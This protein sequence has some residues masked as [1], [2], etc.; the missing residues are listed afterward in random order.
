MSFKKVLL[1]TAIAAVSTSSYAMEAMD[2]SSLSDT[3]GQDGLIITVTPPAAGIVTDIIWHDTDGYTTRT[4]AGAVVIDNMTI[5][6]DS[7]IRLDIDASGD[8]D[9]VATGNQA[10]LRIGVSLLGTTTISTGDLS[11][12]ASNGVGAAVSNQ[13]ATILPSMNLT[14]GSGSLA[15]IFLGNEED[16][17]SMINLNTTLTGGIDVT[18]FAI[19]DIDSSGSIA[20]GTLA[21]DDTGAA[22]A[23]LAAQ[24]AVDAT[25]SGLLV[26]LTQ[27]GTGAG[28]DIAMTNVA[29]GSATVMGD[30]EINGLDL[31]GTTINIVGK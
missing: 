10:G 14:I 16:G 28:I 2:D 1:A 7:G 8:V 19:N 13:T 12:A 31:D 11:V 18:N 30:V 23:N 20:I 5:D 17:K 22:N 15:E 21:I 6:A 24:V 25:A 3:T 29:L 27:I 9:N 4:G 26:T